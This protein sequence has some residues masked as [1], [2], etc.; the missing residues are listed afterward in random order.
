MQPLAAG[1]ELELPSPPR[2]PALPPLLQ[3][4]FHTTSTTDAA[5]LQHYIRVLSCEQFESLDLAES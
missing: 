5:N 3:S 4:L 2:K 1:P